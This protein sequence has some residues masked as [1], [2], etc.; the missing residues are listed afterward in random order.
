M[1]L[2][3]ECFVKNSCQK[4]LRGDCE[5]CAFCVK[6]FKLELL[7]ENSLL[8]QYKREQIKL[9]I[10]KDG[11]DREAFTKLGKISDGIVDF[12]NSGKNLYL[13]SQNCGN[14]KTSWAIRF[15]QNYLNN[16]WH[17]ANIDKEP[18]RAMFI[19]L[20]KFFLQLKSSLSSHNDY[21][22]FIKQHVFD[23]DLVVWDD[24]G[25]KAGTEFE[26][27]NFLSILD[28]RLSSGKSNIY[29][30]NIVPSH[31]K[32]F[33][34]DRLYSRVI[35]QSMCIELKGKDKRGIKN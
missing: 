8:S 26:M 6:L 27:E 1:L 34:G 3:N 28:S 22:D 4:Y 18:C 7:Y 23:C 12:V 14:G 21:I 29:T 30:S 11:T 17:S 31:L 5:Q 32:D 16:V 13:F 33:V 15:V 2:S 10:D 24:V 25:T 20:P 19:S 35:N 9:R